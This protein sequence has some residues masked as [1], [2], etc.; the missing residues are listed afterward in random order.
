MTVRKPA[1]QNRYGGS[2]A[3]KGIYTTQNT[4]KS[5]MIHSHFIPHAAHNYLA[6]TG[7]GMTAL[8][9]AAD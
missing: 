6:V 8:L 7:G 9:S 2:T 4:V 1:R 5:I 3:H